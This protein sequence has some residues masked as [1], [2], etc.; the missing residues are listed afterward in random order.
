MSDKNKVTSN[1]AENL[2]FRPIISSK[3][4]VQKLSSNFKISSN[5][6]V[7]FFVD[8]GLECCEKGFPMMNDEVGKKIRKLLNKR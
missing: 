6:L 4:R 8:A 7:N 1:E 5:A 3:D 2:P